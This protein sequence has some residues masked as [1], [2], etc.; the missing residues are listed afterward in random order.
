MNKDIAKLNRGEENYP[1]SLLE[2]PG[3]PA[4]IF[5]RGTLAEDPFPR[6]AIVGTRKATPLGM[7]LAEEFARELGEL[8]ITI[9]SGL[10]LGIDSAAHIGALK[11]GAKT[12]AVLPCGIDK[13]YPA[14]NENLAKKILETGGAVVSEYAPGM[15]SYKQN[16]LERNRIT[17][18]LSIATIVI[19]APEKS[20]ALRTAGYA[21]EQGKTVFVIPGPVNHPNYRGS[22]AL[23][24]DG[25]TLTTSV[26]EVIADLG[27]ELLSNLKNIGASPENTETNIVID[28]LR[29]AGKPL[30]LDELA[31]LSGLEIPRLSGLIANL[32]IEEQLME[33]PSGYAL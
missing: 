32:L 17:S 21:A 29:K 19:E 9:V 15:V 3:S 27:L 24:R 11:A 6:I 10:A 8:G 2:I 30:T 23:I 5:V 28:L 12:I 33:T 14:Q 31:E 26:K 7:K 16:F 18:G 1:E 13:I 22:H 4:Q 20:G 25:A